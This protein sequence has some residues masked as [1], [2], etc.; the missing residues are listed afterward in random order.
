MRYNLGMKMKQIMSRLVVFLLPLVLGLSLA[1][2]NE[3]ID[4]ER[5]H[6]SENEQVFLAFADSASYEKVTLPG[7]FG[8]GYVYMK[9][10]KRG[11]TEVKPK[12]TDLVRLRYRYY[13]LT[14]WQGVGQGLIYTNY[15]EE[16]P[17]VKELLKEIEGVRIALQN[18]NVGDVAL[19]AV[20]WYLG[21]GAKGGIKDGAVVPGYVSLLYQIEL[22]AIED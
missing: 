5:Q 1:S 11:E 18:M 13:Q 10:L 15:T 4:R 2:C 9:W 12:K 3:E 20:P 16:K 8:D 21:L 22:L 7:F 6:R 17:K 19:V 14:N